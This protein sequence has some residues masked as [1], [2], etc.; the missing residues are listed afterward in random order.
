[1]ADRLKKDGYRFVLDFYGSGEVEQKTRDMVDKLG[2]NDV[3]RFHG[4][5]PNEQVL[6]EMGRHKIFL[7]TSDRLRDG[8]L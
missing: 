5:I 7:F 2:L 1:M 8:V 3:V 4:V 6:R